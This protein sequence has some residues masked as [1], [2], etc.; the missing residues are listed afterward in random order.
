MAVPDEALAKSGLLIGLSSGAVMH[1]VMQ[2]SHTFSENDV[3][4]AI[5]ADSGRAY[6]R[7]LFDC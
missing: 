1:A 7:K 6:L 2:K 3:V 5:L 4:V